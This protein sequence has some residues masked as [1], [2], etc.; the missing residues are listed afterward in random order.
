MS[1]HDNAMDAREN[2]KWSSVLVTLVMGMLIFEALTGLSIYFLPFSV[3]NQIMVLLHAAIGIAFLVPAT[4]YSAKH[5]IKYKSSPMSHYK[6]TG[7]ASLLV[8]AVC[9]VSGVVVTYQALLATRMSPT[10]D[11]IHL[12]STFLVIAGAG[13]HIVL[14]LIRKVAGQ[15]EKAAQR[16]FVVRMGTSIILGAVLVAAGMLAVPDA[17]LVDEFPA[18]YV[19][20]YGDDRPFAP[21]LANTTG[22]TALDPRRLSN[23]ES[24]GSS[25]CHEEIYKEWSVSAHRYSAMDPAFQTIQKVMAEQN[26]A[27]STRYC[28]GCHDPISLFSGSK[29][30]FNDELTNLAGYQE[31]VSCIVCHSVKETDQKGNAAFIVGTPERYIGEFSYGD[32]GKPV[33]DFLIRAYPR[34]HVESLGK[35]LFKTPEY[36]AACHK[37]FIDEEVNNVGWVQLQNQYDNWRMSHWNTPGDPTKTIEC[38]ECHMPLQESNDPAA[39]DSFDYNR[40]LADGKARSHR[41]LGANQLVPALLELEGHEEHLELTEKWLRGEIEIPEIADKWA[42]GSA[43]GLALEMPDAVLPG[44]A[45]PVKVVVTSNKVG[46]DFPTGPLDIIQTWV[47]LTVTDQLGDTVYESGHVEDTNFIQQGAFMFKAEPVDQYGNLIDRHNLWE[48]V[49]VRYRRSLFPGF[50]DAAAYSFECPTAAPATDDVVVADEGQRVEEFAI[51]AGTEGQLTVTARLRY[52]KIDQYLLNFV[53]GE[54]TPLTSPITDLSEA[55][56]TIQV[57]SSR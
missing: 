51:P 39:G 38:R 47:E 42:Q 45:V 11:L 53:F 55:T 35:K 12:V 29:N 18:D 15:A 56:G 24:C 6:L 32:I 5:W 50:S 34:Q 3:P 13:V 43:V 14:L 4:I 10:W 36:C 44:E 48:M 46:H 25:G 8:L 54:D 20:A 22:G 31:G 52:R 19:Y 30:V 21:S 57:V 37:Q 28:G 33:A 9:S 40:T 41:F 7:Y 16:Q 27:E 26:G 49:G 23:S 17:G 1:N 2:G